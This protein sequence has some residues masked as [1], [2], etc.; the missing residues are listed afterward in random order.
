M[1]GSALVI[2]GG[3]S[4]PAVG[5]EIV[6]GVRP[7]RF[8]GKISYS[9]YLWHWPIIV[10]PAYALATE[11]PLAATVG[12]A[13][14][15]IP[16]GWASQ[17]WVE[18]PIRHGWFVGLVPRRNLALAGT[19]TLLLVAS[20][21][22]VGR[23]AESN[24]AAAATEQGDAQASLD[25]ILGPVATSA[26]VA[27]PTAPTPP[28]TTP[29]GQAPTPSAATSP[30]ASPA[31]DEFAG[32][33]PANLLPPLVDATE[34][35]PAMYD[36]GCHV[37][38]LA[39]AP[40]GCVYGHPD[41]DLTVALVGDSH[42][43][44]W[45]PALDRLADEHGWR[46]L[47]MTK[48]ACPAADITVWNTAFERAFTECD[49]W[50]EAVFLRLAD[51]K[52]DLVIMSQSRGHQL[53]VNGEV[54]GGRNA[55][56]PMQAA[57]GRTLARFREV[58]GQ[59]ALIADTPRALSDPPVCLSRHLDDILACATPREE[60]FNRAWSDGE[61]ATAEAAGVEFVDAA[62]WVC[63]TDPCPVV[64]GRYLVYR[65]NHHVATPL[66]EALRT[67]LLAALPEPVGQAPVAG[68]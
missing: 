46:L 57:I 42:A 26:P 65:D 33:V 25:D 17:R 44:Q 18:D 8:L 67:R 11:L 24:L 37:D 32:P 28:N 48:S 7:L 56:G 29:T 1:I 60:A 35:Q 23:A 12:L 39:T 49:Q 50:R 21:V 14:V 41:G 10:L 51:E 34:D 2:L 31:T 13:L 27:T 30:S 62:S 63:P 59:V 40:A 6:L 43:A 45:F 5:P 22:A 66:V 58:A 64:I 54:R 9:L 4:R 38:L 15:A 52:P 68:E 53:I 20:S 3:I 19:L 47:P 36:D 16:V 61:R 55:R